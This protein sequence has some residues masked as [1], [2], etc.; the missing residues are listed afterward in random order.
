MTTQRG[1]IPP[2]PSENYSPATDLLSWMGDQFG[3]FGNTYKASIYGNSA[4]VVRDLD[5]VQHVLRENWQNYTKG[6]LFKRV[7]LL[8]GNG[9]VVSG[10]NLWKTQRR[11]IQPAFHRKAIGELTE[12]IRR[13][14]LAQLR[15][16][17][18]AARKGVSINLTRDISGLVLE[19]TLTAIFGSDYE[20]VA[21]HFNILSEESAR[22]L[23]FAQAF[24]SLGK[25]LLELFAQR[26]K[27]KTVSVD[28]LG[29]LMD[30][31]DEKSGQAMPDRQLVN[32]ILTLIVAGH[33]TTAS[34]LNWTWYLLS[35]HPEAEEK[36]SSELDNL[37]GTTFPDLADLPRFTYTRQ[38]ID[39]TLRLYPAVWLLT[40]R[41]LKD[42]CLGDYF[43][44]AGTEIYISPYF[45]QRNPDLWD[46]PDQFNPD[47]FAAGDAGNRHRLA[48]LPFSA[49][50]RNCVGE[51]L[52]RTE[53]EIHLITIASELRLRLAEEQAPELDVGVNLRSKHD[54]IMSPEL[55]TSRRLPTL[56]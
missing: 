41:A 44:P 2:G 48:M 19:V 17:E 5:H 40:R 55:K 35:Q 27:E 36:L 46:D 34:T 39:E 31:R 43:V 1:K 11:M 12:I 32:E 4:Y 45:I 30:A 56:N 13:S 23:A 54:F 33:E 28:I 15:R 26:R 25:I 49:G 24:R 8:L 29:R 14:N 20:Q 18:Q 37:L 22:T 38:V 52:A 42:D 10:G 3:R 6:L 9:I 51:L 47:R 53:M 50:P 16:W 7:A 21:P